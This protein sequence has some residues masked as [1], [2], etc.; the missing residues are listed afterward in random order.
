MD[1]HTESF[2]PIE[3]DSYEWDYEEARDRG[4]R[5]LWGRVVALGLFLILAFLFG[6]W[7]APA[8]T[9]TAKLDDARAEL[10]AADRKIASLEDQ[11]AAQSAPEEET[12]PTPTPADEQTPAASGKERT[13]IVKSGDTLAGIAVRFYGDSTLDDVIAEANDITDPTSITPG[14]KLIIPPKP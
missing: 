11:L 7:T 5:V 14:Q 13:Y 10:E 8:P 9:L 6:R 12:Q 1:E 2:E 4:P 3:P